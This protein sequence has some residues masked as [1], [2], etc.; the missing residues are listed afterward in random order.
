MIRYLCVFLFFWYFHLPALGQSDATTMVLDGSWRFAPDTLLT[1]G[2]AAGYP[3]DTVTLPGKWNDYTG[4]NDSPFGY[5]TF[6]HESTF[7]DNEQTLALRFPDVLSAHKVFV[8]GSLLYESG[9]VGRS[10]QEE[11]LGNYRYIRML[12]GPYLQGDTLKI[13]VHVSNFHYRTGGIL[14]AP[15][16]GSYDKM[17]LDK[18]RNLFL[19]AMQLGGVAIMGIFLLIYYLF[20]RQDQYMVTFSL[21]C[22]GI[23]MYVFFNGEYVLYGLFP[24]LGGGLVLDLI[25]IAFYFTFTVNLIL[26]SE[27]F[28]NEI[29]YWL[30]QIAKI[31]GL[32]AVLAVVL[33]P[34]HYYSYTMPVFRV[35][36]IVAGLFLVYQVLQAALHNRPGAK[37][38]WV[39]ITLIFL[40]MLNDLLYNAHVIN[41][42]EFAGWG[43]LFYLMILMVVSSRRFSRA[44]RNEERLLDDL[45]KLNDN[46]TFKVQERTRDLEQKS[47]IIAEQQERILRKNEELIRSREE[48]KSM[49]KSIVHDLKAPFNKISGLLAVFEMEKNRGRPEESESIVRMIRQVA[50]E[51]GQMVEDLNVV[52]FFED[53]LARETELEKTDLI[54][55]LTDLVQGYRGYANRKEIQLEFGSPVR[56]YEIRTHPKSLIRVVDNL[57]SNAIKF[58]PPG[59]RIWLTL[60]PGHDQFEISVRDEGPGFTEEDKKKI[61]E[62]FRKLSARPTSGES[63]TG[64]GLNIVKTLTEG[65]GGSVRLAEEPYGAHFI[66][67]FPRNIFQEASQKS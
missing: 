63:S 19:E 45:K 34:M 10:R 16:I 36:A 51:G 67:S 17:L 55:L 56:K 30:I 52:T 26:I 11:S 64:L 12:R 54:Q 23:C 29:P 22:L 61:F 14:R 24:A 42:G 7:G 41:T 58:S 43:V 25:Y 3:F 8:N 32:L 66:V 38:I 37:V 9:R 49:L 47:R 4:R 33:L 48:E 15:E 20:R 44:I 65:M 57:I 40:F 60:R 27:L 6:F 46:L 35:Y 59:T 50:D 18:E 31:I 53:T 2:Q 1:P 5:G 13:L 62:K 21:L 39:A 28:P